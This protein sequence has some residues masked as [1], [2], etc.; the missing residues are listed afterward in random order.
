[1]PKDLS[2]SDYKKILEFYEKPV[3][4][5]Q[6]L[7]KNTAENVLAEK[8]C[9]CIK[10][11]SPTGDEKRAIGICTKTILNK[12]SIRRGSFTCKTK[13]TIKDLKKTKRTLTFSKSKKTKRSR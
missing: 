5:S 3:P 7:L 13:R 9:T 2:N 11:V 10:R 6:R 8:L 1:M 12:R 4:K